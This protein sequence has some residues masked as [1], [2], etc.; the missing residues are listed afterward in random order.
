MDDDTLE[1]PTHLLAALEDRPR[2]RAKPRRLNPVG[3]AHI[4]WHHNDTHWKADFGFTSAQF[5]R[6]HSALDL[7]CVLRSP[8][9]DVVDSRTAL[10]MSLAYM[11]GRLLSSLEGQ[12]GWSR[13]RVSRVHRVVRR[14]VLRKWGH[15]LRVSSS[16]HRLLSLSRLERYTEAIKRKTGVDVIWGAVDGTIRTI[17]RPEVNQEA[18]YN[19]QKR[20]HALKYQ[21]V[22]A[23]DGLIFVSGPWDG[24][25]GRAH[26]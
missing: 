16:R 6:L 25:I 11:R 3:Y 21:F 4:K 7:G 9:G 10:L 26:V 5:D 1:F 12:Y 24:E 18:V 17:A 19:G 22:A 8:I 2:P 20:V 13:L 15:L 14:S 23:P